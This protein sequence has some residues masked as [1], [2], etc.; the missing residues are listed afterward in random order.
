MK[1]RLQ[2][3]INSISDPMLRGCCVEL[4]HIPAFFTHPAALKYHHAYEGGLL[5]HTVE[6]ADIALGTRGVSSQRVTL[7][8]C[9]TVRRSFDEPMHDT[10]IAAAL[11]HDFAK[12]HE[13]AMVDGEWH[14]TAYRD[15]LGHITGSAV[16][17]TLAARNAG[18]AKATIEHVQHCILG[19][20]RSPRVG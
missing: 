12:I 10:L 6:V 9:P 11:W 13:Y 3:H 4:L 15:T 18:V 17:F 8:G 16:E 5:A 2:N 1:H 14:S 19:A 20:P 7:D